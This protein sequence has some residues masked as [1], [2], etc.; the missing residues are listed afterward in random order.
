MPPTSQPSG[1]NTPGGE[2]YCDWKSWMKRRTSGRV[3]DPRSTHAHVTTVPSP[4]PAVVERYDSVFIADE[5]NSGTEPAPPPSG[6]SATCRA[7]AGSGPRDAPASRS[8]HPLHDAREGV[9]VRKDVRLRDVARA[10]IRREQPAERLREA[11]PVSHE[12]DPAH[13]PRRSPDRGRQRR[14]LAGQAGDDPPPR[15]PSLRGE[16]GPSSDRLS[17]GMPAASRALPPTWAPTRTGRSRPPRTTDRPP[18]TGRARSPSTRP[19]RRPDRPPR[20]PPAGLRDRPPPAA[21]AAGRGAREPPSART[22]EPTCRAGT[23]SSRARGRERRRLAGP[24]GARGGHGRD[25]G[26]QNGGGRGAS[27]HVGSGRHA[28]GNA[29]TGWVV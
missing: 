8:F 14:R 23:R 21:R 22:R 19:L 17:V 9:F 10:E 7:R 26:D 6:R 4:A 29:R 11:R 28:H 13:R 5:P 25:Q 1:P 20:A 3:D 18:P 27:A 16:G 15:R 12:A 24:A 2:P